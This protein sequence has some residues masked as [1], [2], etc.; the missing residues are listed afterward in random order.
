MFRLLSPLE[1]VKTT[2]KWTMDQTNNSHINSLDSHYEIN[3]I[4]KVWLTIVIG[5]NG[6]NVVHPKQQKL[7]LLLIPKALKIIL[8]SKQKPHYT[9]ARFVKYEYII[10]KFI[11]FF[12]L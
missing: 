2:N 12:S 4:L 5:R 6:V 8:Y 1:Q 11:G 9:Y 7:W 10:S 3:S